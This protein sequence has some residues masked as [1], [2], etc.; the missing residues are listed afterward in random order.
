[1]SKSR[2]LLAGVA[3][4]AI[5]AGAASA[6]PLP[7]GWYLG[8]N[9]GYDFDNSSTTIGIADGLSGIGPDSCNGFGAPGTFFY[10]DGCGADAATLASL[11]A[12]GAALATP[13]T[14]AIL[15]GAQFGYLWSA[16]PTGFA[17]G[18]EADFAYMGATN[19]LSTGP[20]AFTGGDAC[21]VPVPGPGPG[22]G[23]CGPG[24]ITETINRDW[25]ATIRGRLGVNGGFG[26]IYV[27]GGL[28]LGDST[29]TVT[30]SDSASAMFA[31]VGVFG[32]FIVG[33]CPG[34]PGPGPACDYATVL[35]IT[36]TRI[37]W[38]AGGGWEFA[39]AGGQ[40]SLKLE[41]LYVDLGTVAVAGSFTPSNVGLV[42]DAGGGLTTALTADPTLAASASLKEIVARAGLNF[43]F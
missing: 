43:H 15:G 11:N 41:G 35:S 27:T 14:D 40:W 28:A 19:T 8:V 32:P 26:F 36:D 25:L 23:A 18:I 42:A 24:T 34:A 16:P 29:Y 1:M 39:F 22:S 37:G 21:G 10:F 20:I 13:S 5:S 33:V 38:T 12:A 2:I 4:A 17:W 31:D 30:Y 3:L 9:V 7:S 6:G